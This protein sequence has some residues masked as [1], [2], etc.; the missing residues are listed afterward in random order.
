ME[1]GVHS[2]ERRVRHTFIHSYMFM[3]S[4]LR[5]AFPSR[6]CIEPH[7]IGFLHCIQQAHDTILK[8]QRFGDGRAEPKQRSVHVLRRVRTNSLLRMQDNLYN[9][10]YQERTLYSVPGISPCILRIP[11]DTFCLVICKARAAIAVWSSPNSSNS[12]I[13]SGCAS[14]YK[15]LIGQGYSRGYMYCP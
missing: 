4:V 13:G 11:E 9:L 12:M 6:S 7:S 15:M 14:V 8:S 5:N 10:S 3:H 2:T 1:Y